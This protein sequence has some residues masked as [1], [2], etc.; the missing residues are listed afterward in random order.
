MGQYLKIGV[1]SSGELVICV[2]QQNSWY[3]SFGQSIQSEGRNLKL[4][5]KNL[6]LIVAFGTFCQSKT[7]ASVVKFLRANL[8]RM[9]GEVSSTT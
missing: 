1:R 8:F 6:E 2:A 9:L 3:V 4:G 7:T 5:N